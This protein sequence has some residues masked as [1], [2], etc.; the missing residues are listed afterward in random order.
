MQST[1]KDTSVQLDY[2]FILDIF[3]GLNGVYDIIPWTV[4]ILPG[5]FRDT[6]NILSSPVFLVVLG[7]VIW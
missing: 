2:G 4:S 6:F 3:R 1:C 5:G 7:V